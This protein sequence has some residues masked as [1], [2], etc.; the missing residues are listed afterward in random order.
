VEEPLQIRI[1]LS[2]N[3]VP[4]E[5]DIAIT[6]RTPGHDADLACGFL[7]SEGLLQ[8][9]SQ[10]TRV[11]LSCGTGSKK[12]NCNTVVLELDPQSKVDPEQLKRHFYVSSSC[13]V[14]GKASIESL[15][16]RLQFKLPSSHSSIHPDVI[17]QLPETLRQSQT[18]FD[19]TGGL[20]AAALFSFSGDLL[21]VR[22]DVGRH[23]AVDKLIGAEFHAAKLP[24][25]SRILL[26]SGRASFE[27]VQK[28]LMAGIPAIV[29]VGAPS[30]LAIQ[31]ARRFELTLVG[32]LRGNRFNVYSGVNRVMASEK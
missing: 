25:H 8:S 3:G 5:R 9:S 32:F 29:A 1:A 12:K 22:E 15:R 27:L 21:A 16:P 26:L 31:M 30:S 17:R 14:C 24:L 18:V 10:I 23:N 28:A 13:G 19:R 2:E 4:V 6:M 20:H 7:F 11:R